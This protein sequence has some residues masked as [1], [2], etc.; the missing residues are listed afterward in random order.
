MRLTE[1]QRLQIRKAANRSLGEQA[2]VWLFG[3]RVDDDARG[4]DIDLYVELDGDAAEVLERQLR[5]YATLQREL[6]E[7]R[8]DIVVHRKGTPSRPIDRAALRHG[9][10]L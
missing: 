9:V 5:F 2:E 1:Q 3:S 7:R 6:G 4:G 10:K 8:I